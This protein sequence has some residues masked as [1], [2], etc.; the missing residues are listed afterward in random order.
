MRFCCT[1]EAGG[2]DTGTAV[3]T[4]AQESASV[5]SCCGAGPPA[6]PP[7]SGATL[8]PLKV[9]FDAWSTKQLVACVRLKVMAVLASNGGIVP[10]S[11]RF[12]SYA[13]RAAPRRRVTL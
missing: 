2:E 10:P 1:V 3:T 7:A 12:K 4:F 9:R 8:T 11:G 5:Q 6:P 13:K